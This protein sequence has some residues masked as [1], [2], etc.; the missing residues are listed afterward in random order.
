MDCT[1]CGVCCLPMGY[2]PFF[3]LAHSVTD[4]AEFLRLP[5]SEQQ[6]LRRLRAELGPWPTSQPCLWYDVASKRCSRYDDRPTACRVFIVGGIK[7]L[8]K[9]AAAGI[10]E[11]SA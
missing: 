6:Q 11:N 4:D 9:R 3:A 5:E 8:R 1:D 10:V 7:C 2:P